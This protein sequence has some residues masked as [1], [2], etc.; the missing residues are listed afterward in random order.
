MDDEKAKLKLLI[1][2]LVRLPNFQNN[3]ETHKFD[4]RISSFFDILLQYQ[5]FSLQKGSFDQIN[6]DAIYQIFF[7]FETINSLSI[8][9][10]LSFLSEFLEIDPMNPLFSI[11][12][13]QKL[14][15]FLL[16]KEQS[17]PQLVQN[18][19]KEPYLLNSFFV[20]YENHKFSSEESFIPKI[21]I[22]Y[23]KFY[24]FCIVIQSTIQNN[25][26]T[27]I[28][29][30]YGWYCF[31][32]NDRYSADS[33]TIKTLINDPV[34]KILLIGYTKD[35]YKIVHF[36]I[37]SKPQITYNLDILKFD[38]S[39]M[40]S[41]PVSKTSKFTKLENIQTSLQNLA[42]S[43]FDYKLYY[44]ADSSQ[45]FSLQMPTSINSSLKVYVVNKY[46]NDLW[47]N[48]VQTFNEKVT[49]TFVCDIIPNM[50]FKLNFNSNQKGSDLLY[51]LKLILESVLKIDMS[52]YKLEIFHRYPSIRKILDEQ[53]ASEIKN[54]VYFL[55]KPNQDQIAITKK[56]SND[57]PIKISNDYSPIQLNLKKVHL[58]NYRISEETI[59]L[60]PYVIY[61]NLDKN[62]VFY[63]FSKKEFVQINA[64]ELYEFAKKGI[65]IFYQRRNPKTKKYINISIIEM[66]QNKPFLYIYYPISNDMTIHSLRIQLQQYLDRKG[67]IYI[68]NYKLANGKEFVEHLNCNSLIFQ[69][70]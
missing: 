22:S 15:P 30:S 6:F 52:R 41:L 18:T 32:G 33:E 45:K 64:N 60:R 4:D 37:R 42:Q 50:K 38:S 58:T 28:K 17:M 2:I 25:Y 67:Y 29:D 53:L 16:L 12:S 27:Y 40:E 62:Y 61:Q 21:E 57:S 26:L 44:N 11:P 13:G 43:H 54:I 14:I 31:E 20:N 35:I 34:I 51:Y 69:T 36:H 9:Q 1:N 65:Y 56:S 19:I 3:I 66:G 7:D 55:I 23:Y 49:I 8:S 24:L 59:E 48:Y 47:K 46:E 10:Y 70:K 63:F 39:F 5:Y 68:N